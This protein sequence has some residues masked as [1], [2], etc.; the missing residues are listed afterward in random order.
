M[1]IVMEIV[2]VAVIAIALVFVIVIV[3]VMVTV[4]FMVVVVVRATGKLKTK[5]RKNGNRNGHG[6]T[7]RHRE[8]HGNRTHDNCAPV[9]AIMPIVCREE[10]APLFICSAMPAPMKVYTPL[11][12]R[13]L[14]PYL[15]V[16]SAESRFIICRVKGGGLR[17]KNVVE[18]CLV[19]DSHLCGRQDPR[20]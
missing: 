8:R 12:T 20:S 2:T 3:L 4:T 19:L 15:P 14:N 13:A 1:A 10:P 18:D 5:S 7:D 16:A 6:N 17:A 11:P 9:A